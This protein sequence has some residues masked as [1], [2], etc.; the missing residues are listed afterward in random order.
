MLR[1]AVSAFV[2]IGLAVVFN[3]AFAEQPSEDDALRGGGSAIS[4]KFGSAAVSGFIGWAFS[5]K[6]DDDDEQEV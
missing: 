6:K 2:G 5:G 3:L 1:K 4:A